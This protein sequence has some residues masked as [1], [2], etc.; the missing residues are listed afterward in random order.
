MGR[1]IPAILFDFS[2]V[3]STFE[4]ATRSIYCSERFHRTRQIVRGIADIV[5]RGGIRGLPRAAKDLRISRTVRG[6]AKVFPKRS[7]TR[8]R[9]YISPALI[10][11]TRGHDARFRTQLAHD[12][13]ASL[14]TRQH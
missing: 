14:I 9:W 5:D 10:T 13:S 4:R 8:C 1:P 11:P 12:I 7:R 6:K 2:I 3:H